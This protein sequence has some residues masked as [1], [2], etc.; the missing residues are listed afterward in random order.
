LTNGNAT[1]F[2]ADAILIDPAPRSGY[3][4]RRSPPRSRRTIGRT[5][6]PTPSA[7]EAVM[8]L[9]RSHPE[10]RRPT[11]MA[12]LD[13]AKLPAD[14]RL[15]DVFG[16]ATELAADTIGVERVG[17]WLFVDDRSALRCADLF[18]RS[19]REH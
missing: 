11:E 3:N 19:K 2:P 10:P 5:G 1:R 18:E 12:R 7:G 4:D 6:S 17:V 15:T 14:T 16:R 13:L 9:D 8:A